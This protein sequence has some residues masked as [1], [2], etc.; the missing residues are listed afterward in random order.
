M[1]FNETLRPLPRQNIIFFNVVRVQPIVGHRSEHYWD[2]P[3]HCLYLTAFSF[4]L[5]SSSICFAL[6]WVHFAQPVE[7]VQ[8]TAVDRYMCSTQLADNQGPLKP[9]LTS[10]WMAWTRTRR[11]MLSLWAMNATRR[12]VCPMNRASS[13]RMPEWPGILSHQCLG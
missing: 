1:R 7:A 2:S 11:L 3:D 13:A 5:P 9:R 6:L 4:T 10:R 12:S 8:F